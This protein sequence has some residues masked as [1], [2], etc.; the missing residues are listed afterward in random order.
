MT[1]ADSLRVELGDRSYD[2]KIGEN[3]IA[4]AGVHIPRIEGG[5]KKKGR[6]QFL[7]QMRT[8]PFLQTV[9]GIAQGNVSKSRGNGYWARGDGKVIFRLHTERPACRT[10]RCQQSQA[11][12]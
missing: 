9:F 10:A 8:V 5:Y 4:E 3:L 6:F 7:R 1:P 2:I 11:C 12:R